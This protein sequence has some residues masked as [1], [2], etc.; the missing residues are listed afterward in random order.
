MNEVVKYSNE[1]HELKFNTLTEAQQNVFFT[2]LQQFRNT[3]GYILEL[4]FY[5]I[6]ELANIAQGTNYRRDILDKLSKLQEFKFRYEIN[7]EGDLQQD[8]IFPS[9]ATDSKN[10]VLRI[11]V[12]KDFKDRYIDSPLK[13]WTRYELAEFVGLSGT[14]AKTIYRYLKQ[15]RQTGLWRIKYKDFIEL[16]GIPN[17]YR[18][19]NIDQQ[20]LKP[21]IK[22]L[23]S[24]RNLFDQRRTPF[25]G[26]IIKKIKSGRNIDSLEFYFEPQPI[27]DIE[28]DKKENRRNL[29]TIASD[30]KRQDMLRQL[31][32]NNLI[33]DKAVN[34]FDAYIGR[35][36]RIYNEKMNV[37]DILKIQSFEQSGEQIEV[38]LFN[39]DDEYSTVM[40]FDNFKHFKNTFERYGD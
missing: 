2:I 22:E 19:T 5:K 18:A 10:R 21:A 33:T 14:Y 36:L 12:S 40:R 39:V 29:D 17:S 25:K 37:T 1:L 38:K 6:F 23:S 31:K 13:G 7:D 8:V 15:F 9:L 11:K 26:L 4:D 28:R 35:Y 16:L 3:D 27:S 24:E 32:R 30:I 20:I 34:D